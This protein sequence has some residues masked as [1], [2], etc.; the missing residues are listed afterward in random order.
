MGVLFTSVVLS[1]YGKFSVKLCE[2]VGL[3]WE[4][5]RSRVE[6]VCCEQ[7]KLRRFDISLFKHRSETLAA[8]V[9]NQSSEST[10]LF[11]HLTGNY[12]RE[13]FFFYWTQNQNVSSNFLFLLFSLLLG[14]KENMI[15]VRIFFSWWNGSMCEF[16]DQFIKIIKNCNRNTNAR[17][18]LY[19]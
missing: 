6:S 3:H 8:S 7:T 4:R 5:L 19:L 12:F 16:F 2:N 11:S 17:R 1:V 18:H 9:L 14:G 15:R 13:R 10:V